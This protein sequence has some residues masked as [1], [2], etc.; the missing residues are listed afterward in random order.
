MHHELLLIVIT[1]ITLLIHGYRINDL[2]VVEQRIQS[3]PVVFVV[4]NSDKVVHVSPVVHGSE[5]LLLGRD[6][7]IGR[8]LDIR[9]YLETVRLMDEE[10]FVREV[11]CSCSMISI[12]RNLR[13]RMLMILRYLHFVI[14]V[15]QRVLRCW[16]TSSVWPSDETS[17]VAE[18]E[19]AAIV[20]QELHA[21]SRGHSGALNDGPDPYSAS[22]LHAIVDA[23]AQIRT[24]TEHRVPEGAGG[25]EATLRVG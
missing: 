21:A 22:T 9:R 20:L 2:W 19:A 4:F 3:H 8:G 18:V 1:L 15:T 12:K 5:G 13:E 23:P 6:W 11:C 16:S 14:G 7:G 25:V 10:L 24:G 17:R